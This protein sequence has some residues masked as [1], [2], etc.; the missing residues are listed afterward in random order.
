MR[1][2]AKEADMKIRDVM[3]TDVVTVRPD[4]PLRDTAALLSERRIS[5]VP[6]VDD[7]GAVVGV[8]S[9]ADILVREGGARQRDGLLGWLFDS[10]AT[11]RKL[12]ARTAGEAMTTPAI[13][14]GQNRPVHEAAG[15][16]VT[17]HVNRLPVVADDGR[18]IGI[19]SRADLVRAF[20]RKDEEI[21]DEIRTEILH[22]T[23]WLRPGAVTVAVADGSVKLA[24]NVETE[25]DAELLPLFVSRVPG[26]ISVE[27]TLTHSSSREGGQ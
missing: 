16:M 12:G 27:A 20:T 18:L 23:L 25:A 1:L 8:V 10:E 9:E 13:T 22:R 11:L 15:R 19:V 4:T 24:G 14:I 26:V 2:R 6:V 17:E 3:T 5:G 7:D 21:A